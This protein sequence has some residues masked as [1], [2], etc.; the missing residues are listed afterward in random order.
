MGGLQHTFQPNVIPKFA[1]ITKEY[2]PLVGTTENDAAGVKIL[3][4]YK[5]KLAAATKSVEPDPVEELLPWEDGA[6]A[7]APAAKAAA[8]KKPAAPAAEDSDPFDAAIK[9][10]ND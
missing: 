10:L 6:K 9:E 4:F 1:D 2:A 7:A 3:E 8:K 5:R